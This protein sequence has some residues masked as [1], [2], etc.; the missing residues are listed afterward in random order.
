ME[1]MKIWST[2]GLAPRRALSFW[3]EAISSAFLKVRTEPRHSSKTFQAQLQSL[4]LGSLSINRLQA[5]SYRV[6][7][8]TDDSRR[9]WV[10][11]NLHQRG[12][13]RLRQHGR[14]QWA[15]PGDIS[16]NLGNSPFVF[17]FEDRVAMTC[18]RLPL[19]GAAART[20]R[21]HDAA[22]LPLPDGAGTRLLRSYI[23]SLLHNAGALSAR[24]AALATTCLLDLLA[25]SIDGPGPPQADRAGIRAALYQRACACIDVYL[26]DA[27]FNIDRL[28]AH[29]EMAPRTLQG[30]FHE[31][32]TTF[33]ARLLESRLLAAERLIVDGAYAQLAQ[34]AY[35]VGFSDQSH[36]NKAF[37]R[38]FD[39]TP[40]ER[41]LKQDP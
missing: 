33:T 19:A 7:C 32:G 22:A 10:F 8:N 15:S 38:R 4:S 36:F 2:R 16:I 3:N 28:S 34:V 30:L 1:Q 37:R 41:R 26:G 17:D 14:E 11:I 23:D 31:Q 20:G 35:A 39:M 24:Q 9:D 29:L 6:V 18:L 13:C 5:Q 21:L 40:G 12:E 27:E 25:L